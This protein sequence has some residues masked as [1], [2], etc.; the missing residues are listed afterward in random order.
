MSINNWND[1]QTLWLTVTNIGLGLVVLACI[2]AVAIGVVQEVIAKRKLSA[3][4]K[5]IDREV[6]DLVG[7]YHDGHAFDVPGLGWTM[8]DGGEPEDEERGKR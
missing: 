2:V 1:P 3:E 6:K 5:G 7:A 8:A 4:M